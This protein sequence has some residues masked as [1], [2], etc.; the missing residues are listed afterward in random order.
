MAGETA[1]EAADH[2]VG[3]AALQRQRRDDGVVGA[4]HG[5]GRFLRNAAPAGQFDEQVD[6][7]AVTRI[8][9]RVDQAEVDA[10]FDAQ[11][12]AFQ[13]HVNDVW[14]ADQDRLGDAI[15]QHHLGG[16]EHAF[17]LAIGVDDALGA[18]HFGGGEHRLHHQAG[19]EDEAVQLVDIGREVADRAG[20]DATLASGFRNCRGNAQNEPR[21]KGRGDQEIRP[22]HRRFARIGARGDIGRFLARQRSDGPHGSHLHF[23][24]DRAGATIEC[25]PENIGEAQHVVDL[26]GEVGTA[27]A[28]HRVGTRCPRN[29]GH[30]LGRRIGKRQD[31]RL[32]R[33]QMEQFRL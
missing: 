3:V 10:R 7:V 9:F 22:E 14:S 5:S 18:R 13:S 6:I 15:L 16:A 2:R 23:L 11:P 4:H 17:V 25:P 32:R 33:H 21:V 29:L 19:A 12:V 20:G 28:D 31:E 24:V 30:D 8:V 26:V 27:G 1:L